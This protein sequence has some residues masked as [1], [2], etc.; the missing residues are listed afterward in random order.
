MQQTINPLQNATSSTLYG[1]KATNLAS[2]LQAK[3][4][5]PDGLAISIDAF[6]DEESATLTP[7]AATHLTTLLATRAPDTLFAVRSSAT[8]EDAIDSSWA[9]Q[10]ETF[11]YVAAADVPQK[12][13][14]CHA[15]IK[16]RAKAYSEASNNKQA[17]QVAVVVQEMIDPAYAGV[18]FTQNPVSGAN[19]LVIEYVQGVGEQ[20]VS[21][22]ATPEDFTYDRTTKQLSSALPIPFAT[23]ELI[24]LGLEIEQLFAG[25]P[26]DIEW[27]ID[28]SGKLWI[29]QSRPIT[30]LNI[31][32]TG[33][34]YHYLG[35]PGD[36]F[37]WGPAQG[38]T[39][40]MSD[41]LAAVRTT[42]TQW[43]TDTTYPN[44]PKTLVLL[45][46]D[47]FLWLNKK[48]AFAEFTEPLFAWYAEHG[49]LDDDQAQW[50]AAVDAI[51]LSKT[52]QPGELLPLLTA[53]WQTTFAAEFSLYGAE[54]TIAK[55]LKGFDEK[56]IHRIWGAYSLPDK[57]TFINQIDEKV[58]RLKDPE[59]LA[60]EFRWALNSYAG[61]AKRESLVTYFTQRIKD[62]EG[63]SDAVLGSEADR[64]A[65][66]QEFKLSED[67]QHQL[68]LARR[69]AEFM[70]DR[71]AWMMQTRPVIEK[72]AQALARERNAELSVI[73][74]CRLEDL[75]DSDTQQYYGWTFI[76]GK[77]IDLTKD[78]VERSWDWY[79]EYKAASTV[80]KGIVSSRGGKHFMTG[81]VVVVH[82]PAEQVAPGKI[83]VVPST[84]PSYVPIMRK[85]A[86]L[87][88]DHGGMMSHAAIVA[89][90]F[91]LPCIVGTVHATK[92]LKNG[93]KV[94]L[95]LVKGEVNK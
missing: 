92:V 79:V 12:V 15:A 87:V 43:H 57:P 21:G 5:V 58:L 56:D 20:L 78:D 82:D 53:V 3:L 80:L 54:A 71:K 41:F 91:N 42:F 8:V 11:L 38:R 23:D 1:G 95:D 9:G 89:R 62:L 86:A 73:E 36:L 7:A 63:N 14:Q 88:T 70:D 66:A 60:D 75:V 17:I 83:V 28:K 30:T 90:E 67:I 34:G 25:A 6:T 65:I 84:G 33:E 52:Y 48:A 16:A 55:H 32:R 39:L 4:P 68:N 40:Y 44:P 18:M 22:K 64:A 59:K 81:E 51:D 29:T 69:I 35:D 85:A 76:N 37:Y 94:V 10:F 19:Q 72:M 45:H 49:D 77:N 61:V 74:R 46:Q 24:R 26:Q 47:K 50:R 31:E 27:A 2:M 93:N 13:E